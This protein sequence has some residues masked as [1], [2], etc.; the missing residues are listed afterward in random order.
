M[1]TGHDDRPQEP[2]DDI[3]EADPALARERTDLAWTRSSI[4]FFALGIAIL[5]FQPVAGVPA[6][7]FSVAIWSIGHLPREKPGTAPRR[8]LLVSAAVTVLALVALVLTLVGPASRGLR[9]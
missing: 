5:K 3:E 2:G 4:A 9:P 6:L 1:S 8:V 7:A